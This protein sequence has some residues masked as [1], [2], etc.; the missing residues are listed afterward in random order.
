MNKPHTQGEGRVEFE[1]GFGV[2]LRLGWGE[3][4]GV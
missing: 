4:A 2:D 3:L 1:A